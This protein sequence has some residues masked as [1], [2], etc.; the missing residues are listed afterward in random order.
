MTT[1]LAG[2]AS[3]QQLEPQAEIEQRGD[4]GD[5]LNRVEIGQAEKQL[6]LVGEAEAR[7]RVAPVGIV[8]RDLHV[9]MTGTGAA[10]ASDCG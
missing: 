5:A 2:C 4:A 3:R 6:G 10:G 9:A 7:Q 8:R 1:P